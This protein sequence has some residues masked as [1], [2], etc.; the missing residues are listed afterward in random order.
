MATTKRLKQLF[1]VSPHERCGECLRGL[2]IRDVVRDN[3]GRI[4]SGTCTCPAA[5]H[6]DH[7]RHVSF[8]VRR[9]S[10]EEA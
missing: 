7:A 10:C 2:T 4:I 6:D 5:E 3:S 8:I 9:V 1:G